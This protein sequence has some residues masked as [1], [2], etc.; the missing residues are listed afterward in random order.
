M[1]SPIVPLRDVDPAA[2]LALNNAHEVETSRLD[3]VRLAALIDQAFHARAIAG[4]EAVLIAFDERASYDSPNFLWFRDRYDRFVY[5]DR[6]I[7]DP[8]ARGRGLARRLYEDLFDRAADEGAPRVVCEVNVDP[9]NLASDTFHAAMGF[10]EV[11]R[12]R[13]A[14]GDKTVRYLERRLGQG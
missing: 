12:A 1:A 9:P 14:G 3:E 5:V 6:V 2:V 4:V 10:S 8:R 11:G 13:L 7:T